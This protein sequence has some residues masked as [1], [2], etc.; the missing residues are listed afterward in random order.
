MNSQFTTPRA[1]RASEAH[2]VLKARHLV[3]FVIASAAPLGFSLGA[4]PLLIGR[5]GLGAPGAMLLGAAVLAVFVIG[6]VAMADRAPDSGGLYA[7]VA[8]GFGRAPGAAASFMAVLVYAS[9]ATG[10]IGA[11]ALFADIAAQDVL[12]LSIAWYW[13]AL[14]VT[15]IVGLLGVLSVDL[16]ASVLGVVVALEIVF[17]VVL[18]VA[19]I[20]Q[21]GDSGVPLSPVNPNNVF[22]SELGIMLAIAIAA[23]AGV[24]ATILY[25]GEV[26]DRR[27]TIARATY[28]SLALLAVLY[29]SVTWAVITAFGANNAVE[30]AAKDPAGMFFTAANTYV[31][32]WS[33]K[34]LEVFVV[35]SL[36]ATILAFHNATARYLASMGR[37]R[38]LPAKFGS[39]HHQ[40]G[41]PWLGSVSHTTLS[42]VVVIALAVGAADPYLDLYVLGSAPALIGIPALEALASFAIAA[43]FVRVLRKRTSAEGVIAPLA[44]GVLIIGI[45][46]M[47]LTKFSDFTARTNAWNVVI[48]LSV[49]AML[50]L[51]YI[52]GR[53]SG[54]LETVDPLETDE[55]C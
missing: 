39:L 54:Q 8:K 48:P 32:T 41:S 30:V 40:F 22:T 28:G 50:V 7:Y 20:V 17:L 21:G 35:L 24:E 53:M 47:L 18:S 51:G 31:G 38:L 43:Y 15:A 46:I 3:G 44:A 13:W 49:L 14:A 34:V 12:G 4:I 29:T 26:V 42:L 36:F 55:T 5:G 2:Q 16:N 9:A 27:R 1:Y 45:V 33:V 6:Y 19:I 23:F 11:F 25:S 37:D 52:R 10:A